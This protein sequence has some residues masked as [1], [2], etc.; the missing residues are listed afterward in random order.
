VRRVGNR[1]SQ[2]NSVTPIIRSIRERHPMTY[3]GLDE[4]TMY[5]LLRKLIFNPMHFNRTPLIDAGLMRNGRLSPDAVNAA[6]GFLETF[7]S[8]REIDRMFEGDFS[9]KHL[10]A[11]VKR[12]YT[13]SLKI[14]VMQRQLSEIQRDVVRLQKDQVE[15]GRKL[16]QFG[17]FYHA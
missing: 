7:A 8:P 13:T 10:K 2:N 9:Q 1:F 5:E 4:S 12:V 11:F 14:H 16:V 17:R 3:R 6:Y 15:L